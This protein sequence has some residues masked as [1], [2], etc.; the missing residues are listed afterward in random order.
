MLDCGRIV[1]HHTRSFR[2]KPINIVMVTSVGLVIIFLSML[3]IR[4][5][6]QTTTQPEDWAIT[7]CTHTMEMIQLRIKTVNPSDLDES[8]RFIDGSLESV[9]NC[10]VSLAVVDEAGVDTGEVWSSILELE[11]ALLKAKAVNKE[12]R[13]ARQK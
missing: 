3:A 6:T 1:N 10:K 11:A 2:V 7:R 5:L 9:H 13:K 4:S 8:D 12:V